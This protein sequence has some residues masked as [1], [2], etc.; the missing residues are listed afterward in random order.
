MIKKVKQVIV[1]RNDLKVRKGKLAAQI[2]HASTALLLDAM[3][4]TERGEHVGVKI[5]RRLLEFRKDSTWDKWINEGFTKIVL[6]CEN[7][8]E[9][10]DL[11]DKAKSQKIPCVLITD[12]G[13]TEFN[14]VPT[15]TCIGIG[16]YWSDDIDKITGHL[17][18]L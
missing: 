4:I 17:K 2:A 11:Y 10:L 13:L 14:G 7:E 6:G 16:P 5:C 15:N 1:W 12:A 9:L 3:K 8:N 18:L